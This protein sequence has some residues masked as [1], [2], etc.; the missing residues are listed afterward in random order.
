MKWASRHACT[1]DCPF[2]LAAVK[3]LKPGKLVLCHY[4]LAIYEN[5]L[6]MISCFKYSK[7]AGKESSWHVTFVSGY[8]LVAVLYKLARI[9]EGVLKRFKCHWH[10]NIQFGVFRLEF[11][12]VNMT[13]SHPVHPISFSSL[14]WLRMC[15]MD[16][17]ANTSP[18]IVWYCTS[19]S[20]VTLRVWASCL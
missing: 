17:N 1:L 2:F 8:A 5:T 9:I 19:N 11:K 18:R 4:I 10:S 13:Y 14:R 12:Y 7:I 16:N 6:T 3:L 15:N 20:S